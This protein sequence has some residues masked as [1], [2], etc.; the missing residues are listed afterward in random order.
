MSCSIPLDSQKNDGGRRFVS[1][2]DARFDDDLAQ[3]PA[4]VN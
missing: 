4:S 1:K 3:K 2:Y